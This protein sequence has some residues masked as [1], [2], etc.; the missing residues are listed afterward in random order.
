MSSSNGYMVTNG[1]DN[2]RDV[3]RYVV[4]MFKV[5]MQMRDISKQNK[6]EQ[7]IHFH[8]M[9]SNLKLWNQINILSCMSFLPK[10]GDYYCAVKTLELKIM[11][12]CMC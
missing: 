4:A 8:M 7:K 10:K 12:T 9:R 1:C 11:H 5:K 2:G 3:S 6:I